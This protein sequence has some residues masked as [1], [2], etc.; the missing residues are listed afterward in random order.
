MKFAIIAIVLCIASVVEQASADITRC[1]SIS[2][3]DSRM[4][5]FAIE[6]KNQSWC[7]FIEKA[8]KRQWCFVLTSK[9]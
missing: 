9:K 2:D 3:H 1:P 7:S 4:T 8:D 5:C 6:T